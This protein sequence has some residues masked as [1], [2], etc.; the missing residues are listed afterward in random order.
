MYQKRTS[1]PPGRRPSS[2]SSTSSSP[3][4]GG[5]G[6]G[7]GYQR[8]PSS[9]GY[10]SNRFQKKSPRGGKF[11]SDVSKF[12]NKASL[13]EEAAFTPT[14]SSFNDFKVHDTVKAAIQKQGYVTPTPIQ[15]EAI[16]HLLTGRDLIGL[17]ATGTGKTAAFLIPLMNSIVMNPDT[18]ALI[19][20]PTRELAI[21]IQD[22]LRSLTRGMN[23]F[24][25]VCVGGT[26]MYPQVKLLKRH[27][28][29]V[30]GTPGRLRDLAERKALNLTAFNVLVLDE[31]DRMLDMG[32]IDDIRFLLSLMA[33]ERH[34]VFF[35]ATMPPI[36]KNLAG[37]FLKDP[38]TVNVKTRDTSKDVDQDVVRIP[39]DG[40]KV[41]ILVDLLG[42]PDFNKVLVF[43]KT[44]H[45]VEQLSRELIRRGV[46]S[47]SIHGDKPHGKRQ[48]AL[49]AFKND[50]VQVLIA[51]DV[52]ARGL[53]ISGVSHVI[54]YD[55]P[56]TY[57]DY[58]HRIGRTGRGGK[59]GKA[60]TF[61][62][63]GHRD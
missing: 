27:H 54:N 17:A 20:A 4:R 53:D 16:P 63:G 40:N 31:V 45:G 8:R 57:E 39:R 44:K 43:G 25:L 36:I 28:H 12:I 15:D 61:V 50:H 6:G 46:K 7:G 24:S 11:F 33:E 1:R 49:G 48:K 60:L 30:V 32:F 38:H 55:L 62:P 26:P 22:E 21:Q 23:V 18:Q 9:G 34:T 29:V 5:G 2:S 10:S 13:V 19:V 56:Q 58:V 37:E 52:A 47:E 41:D 3:Y 14:H 51:T 35:S 42:D 59:K